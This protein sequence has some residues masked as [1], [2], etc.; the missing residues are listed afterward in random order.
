MRVGAE[1]TQ[2]RPRRVLRCELTGGVATQVATA[3][4]VI[5]LDLSK[6]ETVLPTLELWLNKVRLRNHPDPRGSDLGAC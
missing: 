5:V 1:G 6:P 4:V 3:V 2:P